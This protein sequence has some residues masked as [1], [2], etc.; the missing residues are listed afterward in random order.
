MRSA[1]GFHAYQTGWELRHERQ[2]L[3]APKLARHNRPSRRVDA[4]NSE[5]ILC[6]VDPSVLIFTFVPSLALLFD[7]HYHP[8]P[9]RG[10]FEK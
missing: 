3:A 1:A 2:Q 7:G 5:Q 10:R 4:V 9:Q 6:Q 8:G